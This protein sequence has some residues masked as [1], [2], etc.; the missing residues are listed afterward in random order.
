VKPRLALLLGF[1]L[2]LTLA[3]ATAI[4]AA[5]SPTRGAEGAA[6][7][8]PW[9]GVRGNRL[10]NRAGKPVRMLGVSRSGAEYAC[11]QGYG[12]FDGP[13]NEESIAA[14][15][16]WRINTVRVPLNETCWL[17]ID[18]ID[19]RYGGDAY[20][21]AIRGYV[22]RLEAAG[23]YVVLDLESAVPG[24]HQAAG[25]PPMPDADHAPDFWRSVAR[26]YRGDRAVVF[27]LYTEPHDVRW[28][29]VENG[30][31][32]G[33]SN[34][35]PYRAVGMRRLVRVVRSTG[36]RQP[37]LLPGIDWSRLFEGWLEHLPPD[38]AHALVA[39]NHTYDFAA[40]FEACRADLARIARHHPVVTSELGEGDCRDDYIDP[41]MRWADRHRVSYIGWTWDAHGGWSCRSGPSLISGYDGAPTPFGR[42]FRDHLRTL[43][44]HRG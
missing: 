25:I 31:E 24:G 40:C 6:S 18:G 41:Y 44:N 35:G 9:I 12:F 21:E 5:G 15:K 33:E 17:G 36:A 38:P 30:C 10:V 29:C 19:P 20:R 39:S 2:F 13:M 4:G 16:R 3:A 27:E 14:M 26:E 34:F 7:R 23:L 42:G 8:A 43:A 32:I 11:Q 1:A 28:G 22:E 37:I